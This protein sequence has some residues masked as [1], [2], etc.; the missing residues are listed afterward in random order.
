MVIQRDLA[1]NLCL[2]QE[3]L[4]MELQKENEEIKMKMELLEGDLEVANQNIR[5]EHEV[6]YKLNCQIYDLQIENDKIK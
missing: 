2:E 6:I 4:V 5:A 1:K 3:T